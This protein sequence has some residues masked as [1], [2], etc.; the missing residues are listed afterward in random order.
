MRIF[1]GLV[2]LM[3]I[4]KSNKKLLV[5]FKILLRLLIRHDYR[6]I[7]PCPPGISEAKTVRT[8]Q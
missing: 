8:K 4:T 5:N 7:L 2:R 6:K 1:Q 3:K